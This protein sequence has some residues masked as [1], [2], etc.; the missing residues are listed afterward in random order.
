MDRPS[1]TDGARE[2]PTDLTQKEKPTDVHFV[3]ATSIDRKTGDLDIKNPL[4]SMQQYEDHRTARWSFIVQSFLTLQCRHAPLPMETR[5]FSCARWCNHAIYHACTR[6][7]A[8]ET[9]PGVLVGLFY[10]P[11]RPRFPTQTCL[12]FHRTQ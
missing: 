10:T 7:S 6:R 2:K 4:D 12:F 3:G 11:L 1:K 5:L 8:P 9:G